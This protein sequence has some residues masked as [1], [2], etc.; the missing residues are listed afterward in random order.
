MT[1]TEVFSV[2]AAGNLTVTGELDG[3]TLDISGNADISGSISSATWT[4]DVIAEGYLQNQSG[5][6]T[7]DETLARINTLNVTELGTISSGVWQGS[8]IAEGYLQ[9][10][11]GTNTGD[12]TLARINTLNVTELGTISSGVWQGSVIAEAY[13]QNQSGTNTGDQTNITGN[14][15]TVTVTADATNTSRTIVF[16]NS[17]STL[18]D[19]SIFAF[20]PNKNTLGVG[21]TP[22]T[23]TLTSSLDFKGHTG[24]ISHDAGHKYLYMTANA[25]YNGGFKAKSNRNAS[26]F[27]IGNNTLA[28]FTD[29]STSPGVGGNLNFSTIRFSVSA[30]GAV[31]GNNFIVSSDRRLKSEIEP[32]K[33]GLEVI[34]QFTSYNYIKD[35]KK[36]SGFIAQEVQEVIPHTVYED[37]EGML[38]MSDRGVVAH[39]HKA[40]LELEKRLISIE[41][42]LK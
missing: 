2:T 27:R 32:I 22:L 7:G 26:A 21:V 8:I 40:I 13:L 20:N 9:N 3:A 6:N 17:S 25:Y 12:E 14:A 41:E 29:T 24:F 39:M 36:E 31:S 15:G 10:Q 42:K 19:S 33:E 35:G 1:L 16:S 5:T 34:K 11:S 37:K 28:F 4:G 23:S 30:S 38:S 18:Y